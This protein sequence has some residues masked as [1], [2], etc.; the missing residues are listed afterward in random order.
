M[1][2]MNEITRITPGRP[3]YNIISLPGVPGAT[4][5]LGE[6]H[7]CDP[8]DT[9]DESRPAYPAYDDH[10]YA[11]RP[12]YD[13]RFHTSVTAV[14]RMLTVCHIWTISTQCICITSTF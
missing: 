7:T 13:P 8:G 5:A 4:G 1:K 12:E 2:V 9:R 3:G 6:C 14:N 11:G 10:V